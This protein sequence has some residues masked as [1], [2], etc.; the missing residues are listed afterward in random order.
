[1][2]WST[3]D[4]TQ[5]YADTIH[6][7]EQEAG[8]G[9]YLLDEAG[10]PVDT[11]DRPH[12]PIRPYGRPPGRFGT[13]Y[14]TSNRD[15]V[16]TRYPS[17]KQAIKEGYY[18][19]GNIISDRENNHAVFDVA[20]DERP[21]HYNP[22]AGPGWAHLVP[23]ATQRPPYGGPAPSLAFPMISTSEAQVGPKD[24]FTGSN[25]HGGHGGHS[26]HGVCIELAPLLQ[27][28]KVVLLFVIV[29]LLAM[30]LV[31]AG[32]L[33]RCLEKTLLSVGALSREVSAKA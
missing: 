26:G 25:G 6:V 12:V 5:T 10:P 14:Q 16:Y 30:T 27:I 20:W 32:R 24:L 33:S 17:Q 31:A 4:Y 1:M 11:G 28:I 22:S 13:P 21:M 3:N 19:G 18:T 9:V 15:R 8:T 2:D 23:S 7:P 29:V